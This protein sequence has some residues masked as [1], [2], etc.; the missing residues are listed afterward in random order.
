MTSRIRTRERH[1]YERGGS[2]YVRLRH[3]DGKWRFE[4]VGDLTLAEAARLRVERQRTY[5]RRRAGLTDE[6]TARVDAQSARPIGEVIAEFI[7]AKEAEGV[8]PTHLKN[9]RASLNAW[10]RATGVMALRDADPERLASWLATLSKGEKPKSARTRNAHRQAVLALCRWAETTRRAHR[11]PIPSGLV[12]KANEDAGRVR[13]SRAMTPDEFDR[14]LGAT[15]P[16][17]RAFYLLAGLTGLRFGEIGRLTRADVDVKQGV[18]Q[19]PPAMTKNRKGA[20][21]PLPGAVAEAIAGL[22]GWDTLQQGDRAFPIVPTLR[23]WKNDLRRAGVIRPG[24]DG[25]DEASG[26]IDERGRRL[27]RKCLRMSFCVWLE[28]AGVDLR[29]A[30]TLMRHSDPK[31]TAKTYRG[32][33]LAKAREAAER[34]AGTTLVQTGRTKADNVSN[35]DQRGLRKSAG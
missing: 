27:D 28:D 18:I 14:L 26:Y 31:L 1:V 15:T 22:K 4:N 11:N 29:D 34:T 3:P 25:K 23:A 6:T 9:L 8:T 2:L 24:G 5:D 21:I 33:R 20:E 13:L 10:T 16:Y 17:R 12:R 19:I 35:D 32:V 30:M 7:A